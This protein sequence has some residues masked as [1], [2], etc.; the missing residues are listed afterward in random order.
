MPTRGDRLALLAVGRPSQRAHD[1]PSMRLVATILLIGTIAL[2]CSAL[3]GWSSADTSTPQPSP[4]QVLGIENR[5]GPQFEVYIGNKFT[6]S[7]S[8]GDGERITASEAPLPWDLK[9]LRVSDK[10][11]V[12]EQRVTRLPLWLEQLGTETPYLSDIPVLG[13]VIT[14]PPTPT[15]EP[16]PSDPYAGLPSNACGGFHLKIVNDREAPV[17]VRINRTWT[18]TVAAGST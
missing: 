15:R 8:C 18:E 17:E 2:G 9:V 4:D 11:W 6:R 13:P 5:G 7:L 1:Q 14:C 12:L 10:E 16:Q 3:P